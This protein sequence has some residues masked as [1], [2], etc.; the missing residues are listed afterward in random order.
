MPRTIAIG[1]VHGCAEEF[2][3]LLKRLELKPD[4]RV[5]QVG[6]LVNRGPDS[7]RVIELAREYQVES[8]IGNHE[9]RLITA[10]EKNK[11]SLLNQYDQVTLEELTKD[12]WNYL[13][14]MPKFLYDAQIDPL[15]SNTLGR[16]V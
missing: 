12:D 10:R 4:D 7:H 9:L 16:G 1:D 14:A 2:E 6:D 15:R 11:P 8:I 3:E 5:I 13:E